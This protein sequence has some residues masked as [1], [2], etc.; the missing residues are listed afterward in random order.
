LVNGTPNNGNILEQLRIN[1]IW[2]TISIVALGAALTMGGHFA[3]YGSDLSE[4]IAISEYRIR[5]QD[6]LIERILSKLD[7]INDNQIKMLQ[8]WETKR[9]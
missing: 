6:M 4:R 2:K 5:E 8:M 9:E 7:K 1:N 3:L